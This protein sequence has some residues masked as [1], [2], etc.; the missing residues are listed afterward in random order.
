M[1]IGKVLMPSLLKCISV[2]SNN[3]LYLGKLSTAKATRAYQR[4]RI[5]PKLC[6][7]LSLL[8]MDMR[9]LLALSAEEEESISFYS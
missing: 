5:Q 2:L 3:S 9:R 8:H 6:I 7:P 4:Y 1:L